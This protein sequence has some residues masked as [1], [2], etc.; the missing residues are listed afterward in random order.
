MALRNRKHQDALKLKGVNQV[1]E[2]T[3]LELGEFE[4]L[5]NWIPAD[6]YS[7]K[8]KRG[9]SPLNPNALNEIITEDGLFNLATEAGDEL[10]TEF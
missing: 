3:D 8:K 9:I 1:D 10:I 5:Q 6:V 7:I 2:E 4:L